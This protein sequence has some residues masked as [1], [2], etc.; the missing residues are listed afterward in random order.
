MPPVRLLTAEQFARLPDSARHLELVDGRVV[1]MTPP[2][3]RH[4][5]IA[6]RVAALLHQCVATTNSGAVLTPAGFKLA[7]NPDTVR[8]PDVAFVR[9]ERIPSAGIPEGYWPGPP[10]LA[11]EIRSPGDSMAEIQAKAADYL[12]KGVTL[13]WLLNPRDR[14]V[15]VYRTGSAEVT[16]NVSDVLDASDVVP[17]FTCAVADVF[18]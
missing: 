6:T 17:G 11:V 2:G 18:E 16:L 13:V 8:E 12:A 15:I 1:Q 3:G 5:A 14:T 10:D 7:S 4:G 9:A